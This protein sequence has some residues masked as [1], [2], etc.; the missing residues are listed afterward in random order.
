[1]SAAVMQ[2]Q[3]VIPAA[4]LTPYDAVAAANGSESA[5]AGPADG[6]EGYLNQKAWPAGF[7]IMW[8]ARV[9]KDGRPFPGARH[10]A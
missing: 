4:E 2:P 9:G 1:M 7:E 10:K 6:A 5:F 3:F 8:P